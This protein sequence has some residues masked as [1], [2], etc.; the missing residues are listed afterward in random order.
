MATYY[1]KHREDRIAYQKA[2]DA[3]NKDAIAAYQNEYY[4]ANKA[5]ITEKSKLY[6]AT[7]KAE[8][9]AY[10]KAYRASR[11]LLARDVTKLMPKMAKWFIER[12]II[13]LKN[14]IF[15]FRFYISFKK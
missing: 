8:R 2:Y 4:E 12:S 3:A 14:R 6:F 9:A 5:K 7:H 1:A 15:F 13:C 11:R 10:Q